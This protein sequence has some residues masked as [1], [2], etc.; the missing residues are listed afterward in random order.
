MSRASAGFADFFPT[1]PSVLQQKSKKAARDRQSSKIKQA[2]SP[3]PIPDAELAGGGGQRKTQE[4]STA[5]SQSSDQVTSNDINKQQTSGAQD[6]ADEAQG[7]LLNGVGSASSHTS[8][9]SSVFSAPQQLPLASQQAAG[10]EGK[11]TPLTSLEYSPSRQNPP[12]PVGAKLVVPTSAPEEGW[13][14]G[15]SSTKS[16]VCADADIEIMTSPRTPQPSRPGARSNSKDV[17]GYKLVQVQAGG[18][19]SR[20]GKQEYRPFGNEV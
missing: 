6:D 20:K 9:V 3:R 13:K 15:N 19:D 1:A 11:L 10:L 5:S 14:S 17:K 8:T 16:S 4:G 12:S 7:D 2:S 18:S